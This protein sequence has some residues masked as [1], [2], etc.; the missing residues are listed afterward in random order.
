MD[1]ACNRCRST[2]DIQNICHNTWSD[3]TTCLANKMAEIYLPKFNEMNRWMWTGIVRLV[4]RTGGLTCQHNSV[5]S[6]Q[7]NDGYSSDLL[8]SCQLLRKADFMEWRILIFMIWGIGERTIFWTV[9][10]QDFT[11]FNQNFCVRVNMICYIFLVTS[12]SI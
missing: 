9:K 2:K 8:E 4:I 3:S 6:D 5:T 11:A 10:Y 12:L 1:N 7:I